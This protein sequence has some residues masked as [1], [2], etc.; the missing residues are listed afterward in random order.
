MGQL[1]VGSHIPSGIPPRS[2]FVGE[3]EIVVDDTWVL[4]EMEKVLWL[5]PDYRTTC[6][7]A[8]NNVPVIGH[9]PSCVSILGF[10]A[11][12]PRS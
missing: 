7:A 6:A 3:R 10:D 12:N 8:R 5:P 4:Q 2:K 11:A 9:V 1:G